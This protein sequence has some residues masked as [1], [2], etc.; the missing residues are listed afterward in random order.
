MAMKF[1]AISIL[2]A[3]CSCKVTEKRIV[4]TYHLRS[5]AKTKLVLNPDKTFLFVKN[6]AEPGPVF[7]PDSTEMNFRTQGTWMFDGSH[8]LV[9]NSVDDHR[10]EQSLQTDSVIHNTSIT[11][12]IFRDS[13]GDAVPI[14]FIKFLPDKIKFYR[15]NTISFFIEDF[16]KTDTM[17]FHFYGYR[18]IRWPSA[19]AEK[20]SD[21]HTHWFTLAEENRQSYFTNHPLTVGR[22]KLLSADK[23]FALYKAE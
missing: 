16:S 7:F 3:L 9:L 4:G 19:A 18:P 10:P 17:E 23:S 2:L 21:N 13:Y 11:S 20:Y 1:L 6:L 5:V 8:K 14:R 12:L 22:R 15:G